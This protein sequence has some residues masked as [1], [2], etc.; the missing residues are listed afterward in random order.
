MHAARLVVSSP[1][2][3]AEAQYGWCVA[4]QVFAPLSYVQAEVVVSL[5]YTASQFFCATL[6]MVYVVDVVIVGVTLSVSS[7]TLAVSVQ[8]VHVTTIDWSD[9]V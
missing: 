4:V 3:L 8:E 2:R 5:R 9:A 1:A 7:H 6:A